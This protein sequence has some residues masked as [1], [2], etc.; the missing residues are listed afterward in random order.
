MAEKN[1]R[2][3]AALTVPLLQLRGAERGVWAFLCRLA[4]VLIARSVARSLTDG[5][6]CL[7]TGTHRPLPRPRCACETSR[8]LLS[9]VRTAVACW[10][11]RPFL[12]RCMPHGR[13]FL[14]MVYVACPLRAGTQLPSSAVLLLSA[15]KAESKSSFSTSPRR[16][17]GG[18]LPA[19][20]AAG[21]G[22]LLSPQPPATKRASAGTA[23]IKA[24][25]GL[26]FI[27]SGPSLLCLL[28]A[29]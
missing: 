28:V 15:P 27:D 25:T 4:L 21:K 7:P 6:L 11:L 14:R 29:D 24:L 2:T 23:A 18:A 22:Q 12:V 8:P 19:R 26:C 1:I 17:S 13:R 9:T 20:S 3:V 5:S 10:P 16:A